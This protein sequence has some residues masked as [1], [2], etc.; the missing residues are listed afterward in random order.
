MGGG[1]KGS[2]EGGLFERKIKYNINEWNTN[3]VSIYVLLVLILDA[4]SK[5]CLVFYQ[6]LIFVLKLTNKRYPEKINN[7]NY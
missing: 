2:G 5:Q 3:I 6:I 4:N 7:W 1:R